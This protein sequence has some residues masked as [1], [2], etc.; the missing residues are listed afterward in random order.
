M[1]LR[2]GIVFGTVLLQAPGQTNSL[3]SLRRFLYAAMHIR[4]QARGAYELR[5]TCDLKI[6]VIAMKA[7]TSG[8]FGN[9]FPHPG[10]GFDANLS[11]CPNN[12]NG[13]GVYRHSSPYEDKRA[14]H[15]R[16]TAHQ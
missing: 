12:F 1:R 3:V 11:V 15:Q 5:M 14:G 6:T 7:L 10:A 9:I 13:R 4:P 16:R 2:S 8:R